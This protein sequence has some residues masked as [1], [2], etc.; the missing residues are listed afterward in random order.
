MK[1]NNSKRVFGGICSIIGGCT[2]IADAIYFPYNPSIFGVLIS[3]V[4]IGIA[5]GISILWNT[6]FGGIIVAFLAAVFI[7]CMIIWIPTMWSQ[8][9][10]LSLLYLIP[11]SL[12]LIGGILDFAYK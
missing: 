6:D 4:I 5:G 7:F 12:M 10:A 8:I 9:G 3:L 11:L 1:E 2:A